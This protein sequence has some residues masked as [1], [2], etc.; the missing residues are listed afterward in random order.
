MRY[1]GNYEIVNEAETV[2]VVQNGKLAKKTK[3]QIANLKGKDED[4]NGSN[5]L[6]AVDAP[7]DDEII[8]REGLPDNRNE[9]K[10]I[11]KISRGEAFFCQGHAGWGKSS[12]IKQIAKSMGLTI[13][14]VYLDKAERTDLGGIPVPVESSVKG[15]KAKLEFAMPTWA[16]YMYERPQTKFLLFFD[17][18]NQAAPDV[19][20]ALMPIVLD[21]EVA[22]YKFKN[23]LVGAAGNL[24]EE[25][26]TLNEL[27]GPLRDRFGTPILWESNTDATWKSAVDYLRST[28]PT[29]DKMH[30]DM[31]PEQKEQTWEEL[32]GKTV[33]DKIMS[34]ADLFRNPRA[35]E[36]NVLKTVYVDAHSKWH[37]TEE[38]EDIM[39]DVEGALASPDKSNRYTKAQYKEKVN[40]LVEYL[41]KYIKAGGIDTAAAAAAEK[42]KTRRGAARASMNSKTIEA[43]AKSLAKGYVQVPDPKN[44]NKKINIGVSLESICDMAANNETNEGWTAEEKVQGMKLIQAA[45]EKMNKTARFA[46]DEEWKKAGYADWRTVDSK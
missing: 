29:K 27:P 22:N 7:T 4:V 32:L 20:N 26:D 13:L 21:N 8:D 35:L 5:G 30:S 33:F 15:Q 44:S 45:L 18:M 43:M 2:D 40:E 16:Q 11:R 12:V 37:A 14:T 24:A 39:D 19:L 42:K 34:Y 23:F 28:K 9:R 17:E 10:L 46:T 38:V 25:N 36:L 6:F 31:F 41:I 1:F 3:S